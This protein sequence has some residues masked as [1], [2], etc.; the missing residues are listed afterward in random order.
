MYNLDNNVNFFFILNDDFFLYE[1]YIVSN[2]EFIVTAD[3]ALEEE[4]AEFDL[5]CYRSYSFLEQS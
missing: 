3:N 4:F 5:A 1:P 2:D